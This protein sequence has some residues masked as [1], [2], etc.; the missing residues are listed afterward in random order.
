MKQKVGEGGAKKNLH[1]CR[2]IEKKEER[3]RRMTRKSERRKENEAIYQT[4][5][6]RVR[7]S[8]SKLDSNSNNMLHLPE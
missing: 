2:I 6:G 5:I 4:A 8:N 3:R 7:V 1:G